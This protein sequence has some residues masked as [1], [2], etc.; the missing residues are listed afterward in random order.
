M[1]EM[2]KEEEGFQRILLAYQRFEMNKKK[3][4]ER[5]ALNLRSSAQSAAISSASTSLWL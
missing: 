2:E 5:V 1:S 3:S 4:P